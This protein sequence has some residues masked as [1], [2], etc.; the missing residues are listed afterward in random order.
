[1]N[2][3]FEISHRV[4]VITG[5]L[6]KLGF[7]W[8]EVLLENGAN[9][10]GIDQVDAVESSEFQELIAKYGKERFIVFRGDVTNKADV[11][12]ALTKCK[13]Y[14]GVPSILVNNAG[15][16]QPP[17]SI[18]SYK[19]EEIP[20]EMFLKTINVNLYGTFLVSQIFGGEMEHCGRGSIINI[21]SLY[22]GVSPDMNFYNHIDTDPPFIKPPAYGASKAGIINL[23]K[24]FS[25]H[26]GNR[27]IRVNALSPGGVLGGQD[28]AF[29]NKFCARVPLGRLAMVEDLKGPLLFLASD[30]SSYVTG[31]E[32][33]V[34]GGFTAW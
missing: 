11:D 4:A 13:S 7:V 32:L 2:N 14:F 1:M 21:G 18:K 6:G 10:F 24:Y 3:L 31:I 20:A 27:G 17:D 15:I 30:A 29:K 25:T 28:E 16:D 26:W 34:D 23:T 12:D 19:L 9:V 22:A 33:M 5:I 8:A